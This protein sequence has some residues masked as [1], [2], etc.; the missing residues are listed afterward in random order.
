MTKVIKVEKMKLHCDNGEKG[1]GSSS[2]G[3]D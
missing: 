1:G 2:G 3:D